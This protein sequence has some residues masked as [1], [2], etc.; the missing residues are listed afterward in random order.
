MLA[1]TDDGLI[2]LADGAVL[3]PR[4]A[5]FVDREGRALLCDGT[6]LDV[7]RR[8][9]ARVPGATCFAVTKDGTWLVGTDEASLFVVRGGEA[10]RVE[11]FERAPTRD[12]WHT[13]WG[14]PP[15]VRSVA[16]TPDRWYVSVH[17][18]GV[19]I[20]D[21]GGRSFTDTIDLGVDVHQV[22]VDSDGGAW[23]ANGRGGLAHAADGVAHERITEGL[24][25]TYARAVAVSGDRVFLSVST[26]PGGR[27][28]AIYRARRDER[29]LERCPTPALSANVDT[30]C[31]VARGADVFAATRDAVFHSPNGGAR[32][33]RIDARVRGVRALGG[34]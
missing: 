10:A 21:D 31:L 23:L 7:E 30:H 28:S 5:R 20:S 27:R 1:A 33:S 32:W 13:P 14:G 12:A 24:H 18:G 3:D 6:L 4:S 29:R 9:A 15:A 8:E 22:V 11:A 2:D 34:P 17:V 25:A 26:G 16:V 19:L